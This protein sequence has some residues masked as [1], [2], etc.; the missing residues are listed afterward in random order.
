MRLS[1]TNKRY[2]KPLTLEEAL[3]LKAQRMKEIHEHF[4]KIG[5]H[6]EF[7]ILDI[8]NKGS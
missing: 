8:K 3:I 6:Q 5:S 1:S 7:E 2:K 4:K